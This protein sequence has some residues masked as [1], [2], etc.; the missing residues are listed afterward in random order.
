MSLNKIIKSQKSVKN[1]SSEKPDWR[2][3]IEA[4]DSARYAPMAGGNYTP[5]F[6]LVDDTEKIQKLAV[7]TQ[8]DFV[9]TAHYVVVVCSNPSR[10]INL[11]GK[12]GEIYSHQ[13]AGAAIQNFLLKIE[14]LNLSTHWIRHFVD[15]QV[16]KILNIPLNINVE[17]I[18]PVGYE[19]KKSRTIK[20]KI[21]LDQI[22]YFNKYKNK[23]MKKPRI[24]KQWA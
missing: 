2:A 3:I 15:S 22:L 18:L 1:F 5:K 10:V 12:R 6:I 13:Q 4:I 17:A 19:Y 7:A 11:Y 21:D 14:Y 8:E 16:R 23:K 24:V 20:S 9:A